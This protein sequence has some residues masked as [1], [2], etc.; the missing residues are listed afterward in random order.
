M[1]EGH[2]DDTGA[3]D[4]NM[5]LSKKRAQSVASYFKA[6]G[7]SGNRFSVKGFGE[8]APR[9][10]NDTDANRAKNRRVEIGIS[11]NDKMIEEAKA[12]AN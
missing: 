3:E 8:S 4:Y 2:T 9:F 10:A 12:Q 1:I 6:K 11:A 7:I 5:A